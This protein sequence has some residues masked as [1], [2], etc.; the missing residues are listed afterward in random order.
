MDEDEKVE[1]TPSDPLKDGEYWVCM[2]GPVDL[3]EDRVGIDSLPR[4]AVRDAIK[5]VF[6]AGEEIDDIDINIWSRWETKEKVDAL[7]KAWFSKEE[8]FDGCSK[9]QELE[10]ENERLNRILGIILTKTGPMEIHNMD[11][12]DFSRN[13]GFLEEKKDGYFYR[14]QWILQSR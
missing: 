3:P 13:K 1:Q 14:Y 7:Q 8:N 9:L 10:K 11:I 12:R 6:A 2:L 5:E 4:V